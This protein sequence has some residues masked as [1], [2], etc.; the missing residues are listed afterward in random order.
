MNAE[1]TESPKPAGSAAARRMRY[2]RWRRRRGLRTVRLLLHESQVEALVRHGYL[3][4]DDISDPDAVQG[5]VD[6]FL[7]DALWFWKKS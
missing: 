6:T 7:G 5:A 2:L 4:E 3:A 1:P